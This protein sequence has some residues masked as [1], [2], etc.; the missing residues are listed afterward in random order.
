MSLLHLILLYFLMLFLMASIICT[1]ASQQL[2]CHRIK[3]SDGMSAVW[4]KNRLHACTCQPSYSES[5]AWLVLYNHVGPVGDLD[6]KNAKSRSK[7]VPLVSFL[8]QHAAHTTL[9][10]V[11]ASHEHPW[12]SSPP[13]ILNSFTLMSLEQC[14]AGIPKLL[15]LVPLFDGDKENHTGPSSHKWKSNNAAN[16]NAKKAQPTV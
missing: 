8:S 14:E 6:L 4:G 3:S 13:D 1:E 10:S 2:H 16:G 9:T 5:K 7:L 12:P 15:W 11:C